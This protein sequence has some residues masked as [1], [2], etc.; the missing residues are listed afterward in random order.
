MGG[1]FGM[2]RR[3]ANAQISY[4]RTVFLADK[5]IASEESA[6]LQFAEGAWD[7]LMNFATMFSSTSNPEKESGYFPA[8]G[9]EMAQLPH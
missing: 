8:L 2:N 4:T 9:V 6:S 7:V 1:A 3:F 5:E